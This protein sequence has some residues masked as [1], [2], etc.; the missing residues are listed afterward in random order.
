MRQKF[1]CL[2][3]TLVVFVDIALMATAYYGAPVLFG[4]GT[5]S[6]ATAVY[7]D[8]I[9]LLLGVTLLLFR[10][11]GLF[12]TL[13]KT[14]SEVA[15]GLV[16]SLGNV[17]AGVLLLSLFL[18]DF[19]SLRFLFVTALF[20]QFVVLTFWRYIC[21]RF[22]QS[23]MRSRT[24]LLLGSAAE[25]D[26]IVSRLALQG[27]LHDQV[28]YVCHNWS[29]RKWEKLAEQVDVIVACASLPLTVKAQVIAFCQR[30]NKQ[31]FL[32]PVF[33]DLICHQGFLDKIDDIPFFRPRYLQPTLEQR[34]LKRIFD[35]A[36]SAVALLFLSPLLLIVAAAIKWDSKGPVF[37][38]QIRCGRDERPFMVYKFRTMRRD[39][40]AASGPVMASEK[41]PRI[42]FVGSF[43]RA[44]RLDEIPQFVN[45]LLGQMSIVGPRP[46]RPFFVENFKQELSA[47]TYRHRV[48]PGITGLAQI[49]GKYNTTA[50]DKLTYDLLYIQNMNL[51]TDIKI[52]LQTFRVL[53]SKQSTEGVAAKPI[54][55]AAYRS[56]SN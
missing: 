2:L 12:A 21:W 13:R 44:T 55:E 22:D 41:D 7:R 26:R 42:T 24:L 54:Q 15:L 48:K 5:K 51:F 37:Y 3:K 6:A 16:M 9:P 34:C 33:Y 8:M 1:P 28:K 35:M 25:S 10:A 17:A 18:P 45:V 40:E 30:E 29:A 27:H 31:V 11:N 32:V 38:G 49:Y 23:G 14:Y 39:A 50:G 47:Y 43:L 46:E 53:V 52:M 4:S 56:W 36:F 19:N 20:T